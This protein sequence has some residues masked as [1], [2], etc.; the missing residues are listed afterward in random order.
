MR[1]WFLGSIAI[2]IGISADVSPPICFDTRRVGVRNCTALESMDHDHPEAERLPGCAGR[3]TRRRAG[4]TP[5]WRSTA[6]LRHAPHRWTGRC[7]AVPGLGCLEAIDS[8]A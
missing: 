5:G 4:D 1:C 8:P 7:H 3:A 6:E 2:P